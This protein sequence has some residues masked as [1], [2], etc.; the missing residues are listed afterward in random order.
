M[1]HWHLALFLFLN[2]RA[3]AQLDNISNAE[4]TYVIP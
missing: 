3:K 2:L 1:S 4:V